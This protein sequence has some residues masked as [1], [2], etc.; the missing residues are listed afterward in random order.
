[1]PKCVVTPYLC[2]QHYSIF[3]VLKFSKVI[4][5]HIFLMVICFYFVCMGVLSVHHLQVVPVEAGRVLES[6]KLE[7]HVVV[8][9]HTGTG[10]PTQVLRKSSLRDGF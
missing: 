5:P 9:Y 6:L 7:M 10:N 8:V 2:V 3:C 4:V 1:M